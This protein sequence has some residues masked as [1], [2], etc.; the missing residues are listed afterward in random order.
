MAKVKDVIEH[1]QQLNPEES[2]ISI[3]IT[4]NEFDEYTP[5]GEI[6]TQ[7]ELIW[8]HFVKHSIDGDEEDFLEPA[9]RYKDI[10]WAVPLEELRSFWKSYLEDTGIMEYEVSGD[11]TDEELEEVINTRVKPLLAEFENLKDFE[12]E[13]STW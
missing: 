6:P 1:L 13:N 10:L 11:C 2:I 9:G 5:Y 4:R 8:N 3:N 12:K 7:T